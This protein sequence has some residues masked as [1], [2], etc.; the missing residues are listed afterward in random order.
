MGTFGRH[1][2]DLTEDEE[3]E[4]KVLP[5]AAK[6]Q[7]S[8]Q[9]FRESEREGNN[10]S[11]REAVDLTVDSLSPSSSSSVSTEGCWATFEACGQN[12]SMFERKRLKSDET[13]KR[14][15]ADRHRPLREQ[16]ESVPASRIVDLCDD[17][18]E[19]VAVLPASSS[20]SSAKRRAL[21]RTSRRSDAEQDYR[22]GAVISLTSPR[23][24]TRTY[25]NKEVSQ[26]RRSYDD[27]QEDMR[28]RRRKKAQTWQTA[29]P[30]D[31]KNHEEA[32][33]QNDEQEKANTDKMHCS[34][35][36]SKAFTCPICFDELDKVRTSQ[37]TPICRF[38]GIISKQAVSI[39]ESQYIR[40]G[41][42]HVQRTIRETIPMLH[43]DTFA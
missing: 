37:T 32:G 28:V 36:V 23:D 4:E 1:N 3:I 12:P 13:W 16:P 24:E 41:F 25:F 30:V 27:D 15:A 11:L 35:T 6:A 14:K 7:Q 31:E 22:G 18:D 2:L 26:P 39:F 21:V 40:C 17:D 8:W 19:D 9:K 5:W 20:T 29:E 43:T 34:S 38:S 42:P 33:K 10:E